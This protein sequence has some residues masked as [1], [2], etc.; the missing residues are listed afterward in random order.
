MVL[1]LAKLN[2]SK[3]HLESRE[4]KR[5]ARKDMR[6]VLVSE[7]FQAIAKIWNT[8]LKQ[9][10]TREGRNWEQFDFEMTAKVKLY[11]LNLWGNVQIESKPFVPWN[12]CPFTS[13][14]GSGIKDLHGISDFKIW[15]FFCGTVRRDPFQ[16][17]LR[18]WNRHSRTPWLL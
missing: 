18:W 16:K 13:K 7:T 8:M 14:A 3:Y 17:P 15:R 9:R 5:L 4:N 11:S 12:G 2:G 1:N 10:Q 6:V